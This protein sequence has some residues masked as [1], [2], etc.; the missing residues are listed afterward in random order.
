MSP[1]EVPSE[2]E[3]LRKK[4]DNQ[5]RFYQQEIVR[6]E[7]AE[8]EVERL[9]DQP[10]NYGDGWKL[11][12][13]LRR[14]AAAAEAKVRA[15]EALADLGT[16][17]VQTSLLRTALDLPTEVTPPAEPCPYETRYALHSNGMKCCDEDGA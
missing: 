7:K 9:L 14:R 6:R 16:R 17:Y 8:A 12:Q 5:R 11:V 1:G 3:Q 4:A 13:S 10:S 15:V 2:T